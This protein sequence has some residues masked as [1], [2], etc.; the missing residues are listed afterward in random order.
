MNLKILLI[1]F[2]M[3]LAT[4]LVLVSI[5]LTWKEKTTQ[6]DVEPQASLK[7]RHNNQSLV[8]AGLSAEEM[9]H[10]IRYLQSHLGLPLVDAFHANPSDNCI[11]Y[12]DLQLPCKDEVLEFL[13]H[14]GAFPTRQALVVVYFGGQSDPNITEYVVGPLPVPTYHQDVTVQKY[15]GK[16]PYHS[17]TVLGNEYEQIGEF[18]LEKKLREA[19]TFLNQ[20]FGHNG[21]NFQALTSAPRGFQSGDRAT[22]F[23]LFQ[24]VPGFFLH[25]VGLELLVDHSSL[26]ISLWSVPKVFYNGQY[27]SGLAELERAFLE[28]RVH[29]EKVKPVSSDGGFSSVNPRVPPGGFG[30]LHYEPCGPRYSV[31]NNQVV[32]SLWSFAFRMDVNRGPHIY[33]VRFRGH[34]IVYELSVQDAMS[35]YGSNS[36]GGMSTRYMDGNFGMGRFTYSLVKGVDCPY[37][38]TYL[39]ATYLIET[40]KPEVQKNSICVFEESLGAPFRRHYSN[41][42]SLFYGG[43]PGSALVLRSVATMGNYDYVWD[44]VFHLNG[45]IESKVRA[46]GYITSS[47]FYGDG[48]DYGN[49]VADHTLGTIHT[50]LINYKVD[51]DV[52]DILFYDQDELPEDPDFRR[53][54]LEE[55]QRTYAQ[56][57]RLVGLHK[58]IQILLE[59]AA[60]PI[61]TA[62]AAAKLEVDRALTDQRQA[63]EQLLVDAA[64]ARARATAGTGA[65]KL[66]WHL[67][68]HRSQASNPPASSLRRSQHHSNL[69]YKRRLGSWDNNPLASSLW[70]SQLQDSLRHLHH[71][72]GLLMGEDAPRGEAP[73]PSGASL[74]DKKRP[75]LYA[76]EK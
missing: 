59:Q 6:C 20:V 67:R 41:L 69:R 49:R 68:R 27:Y 4:I 21:S 9:D 76:P 71:Q 3:A 14:G 45:A 15:G 7:K 72:M 39:D 57:V 54:T 25:P 55:A 24:N 11:Y 26:N 19:P 40:V 18:L 74:Q 66:K 64:A 29:V 33:D 12:V 51:L 32:S 16:I 34:R 58:K 22:W 62:A 10:V 53:V 28:K 46:T 5:L 60:V 63:E 35:V 61:V 44:F 56:S 30:P 36:P 8:F 23:A 43:L 17:R 1:L 13:D 48:L 70:R 38:A 50:H 37:S 75:Q 2:M 47:F 42:Q 31:S 65:C 73:Q 52:A